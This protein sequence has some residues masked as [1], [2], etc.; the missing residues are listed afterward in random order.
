ML[1]AAAGLAAVG[2]GIII[3]GPWGL[4]AAVL[5]AAVAMGI[6]FALR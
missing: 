3:L 5:V 2:I 6:V 1:G 4:G